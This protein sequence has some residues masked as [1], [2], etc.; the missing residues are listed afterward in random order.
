MPKLR[1][2]TFHYIPPLP[3]ICEMV[4]L[5]FTEISYT[6]TLMKASS[7]QNLFNNGSFIVLKIATTNNT[8][9]LYFNK[10]E[11]SHYWSAIFVSLHGLPFL[12]SVILLRKG[13][14]WKYATKHLISK[15]FYLLSVTYYLRTNFKLFIVHDVS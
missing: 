6:G 5:T 11:T 14:Q 7:F 13:C 3:V 12:L 8:S 10:R 2:I 9:K 1:F 15:N 4:Q